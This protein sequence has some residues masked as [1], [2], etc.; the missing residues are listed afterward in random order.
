MSITQKQ[1]IITLLPKGDNPLAYIKNWRPISLLNVDYK[2]FSGILA[3]RMKKVLPKIIGDQQKR[4]LIAQI[5][6]EYCFW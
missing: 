1:G 5:G 4:F 2:L 3:M 6:R